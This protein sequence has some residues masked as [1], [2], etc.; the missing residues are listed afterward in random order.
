MKT[1]TMIIIVWLY[2]V[3]C[4]YYINIVHLKRRKKHE[5]TTNYSFK[6]KSEYVKNESLWMLLQNTGTWIENYSA[7]F[8]MAS[9]LKIQ[10]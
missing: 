7:I 1:L 5:V 6:K 2:F 4:V 9:N 10:S 3:F 8:K